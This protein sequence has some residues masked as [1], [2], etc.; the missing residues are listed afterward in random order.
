MHKQKGHIEVEVKIA[1]E[2]SA[3]IERKV[4]AAG[5]IMLGV[6]GYERNVRY[7]DVDNTF[8]PAG[9]VLRLREDSRVRLTYKEPHP[10]DNDGVLTRTELEVTVSDFETADLLLQKLGFHPAWIYEKYRT[11]YSL[12][13]CE[14]ALDEMPFGSFIEVEG[15]PEEIEHIL[16]A[17]GLGDAKRITESY[18]DIFFRLKDQL[19]LTFDDLTFENFRDV[20][21]EP[22]MLQ[23]RGD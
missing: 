7:E 11:S 1:I 8:T 21:I 6:R 16:I 12:H 10:N 14:I 4:Q 17:L 5:G 22:K 18:S 23:G 9:R 19:H 2:D 15:D 3:E 13:D 20:T